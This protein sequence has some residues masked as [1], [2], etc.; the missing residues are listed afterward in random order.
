MN[1]KELVKYYEDYVRVH[2]EY[3]R[4]NSTS[5]IWRQYKVELKD[6]ELKILQAILQKYYG[7]E[8]MDVFNELKRKADLY[9]QIKGITDE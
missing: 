9:D 4:H 3:A 7:T 8:S 1:N 6:I 5:N 2:D